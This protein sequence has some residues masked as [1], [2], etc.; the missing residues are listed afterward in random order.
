MAFSGLQKLIID[1]IDG[2]IP[3]NGLPAP[4]DIGFIRDEGGG[5][6]THG[7]D[8]IFAVA[9]DVGYRHSV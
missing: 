7:N 1:G 3:G 5:N 6:T 2:A 9:V 4:N 8:I